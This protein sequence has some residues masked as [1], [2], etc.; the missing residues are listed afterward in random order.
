MQP[1][2]LLSKSNILRHLMFCKINQIA[3]FFSR[4]LR[5]LHMTVAAAVAHSR[6]ASAASFA[7]FECF[8]QVQEGTGSSACNGGPE[9]PN[10]CPVD[11]HHIPDTTAIWD[12]Q[13]GLPIKPDPPVHHPGRFS[14]VRP[15]SPRWRSCLGV[16]F[17]VDSTPCSRCPG[18]HAT[19]N[20]ISAV[21]RPPPFRCAANVTG[22][23]RNTRR[24]QPTEI[25]YSPTVFFMNVMSSLQ[26]SSSTLYTYIH[27]SH[28][29]Q[30]TH[31]TIHKKNRTRENPKSLSHGSSCH[32]R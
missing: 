15:G 17:N 6:C 21:K 8:S 11:G 9:E 16:V 10:G 28:T 25:P 19:L 3:C 26:T 12:C 22:K 13:A 27:I 31:L 4:H 7:S 20:R 14:A 29:T 2:S 24:Q 30:P 32:L 1:E 23:E 18:H 5:H